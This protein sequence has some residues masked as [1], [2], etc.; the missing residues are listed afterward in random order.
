MKQI[1]GWWDFP[2]LENGF[3]IMVE[4]LILLT[5]DEERKSTGHSILKWIGR[6]PL[7]WLAIFYPEI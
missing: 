3:K 5:L 1:L 4:F 7:F 6:F 2:P